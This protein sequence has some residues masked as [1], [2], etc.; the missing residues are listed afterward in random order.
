MLKR[1]ARKKAG[2]CDCRRILTF[3]REHGNPDADAGFILTDGHFAGFPEG[4]QWHNQFIS[5]AMGQK[6]IRGDCQ[7][8][9]LLEECGGMYVRIMD[10]SDKRGY[11]IDSARKPTNMQLDTLREY[12]NPSDFNWVSLYGRDCQGDKR[13]RVDR[14]RPMVFQ[15]WIRECFR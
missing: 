9:N 14:P 15:R 10:Y 8:D 1:K 2:D 12:F 5:R 13:I 4:V 3:F 6:Y 7:V 11:A